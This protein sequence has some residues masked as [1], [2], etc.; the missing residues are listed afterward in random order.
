MTTVFIAI[1]FLLIASTPS[2]ANEKSNLEYLDAVGSELI[3]RSIPCYETPYKQAP[4]CNTCRW[5]K[6]I[7]KSGQIKESLTCNHSVQSMTMYGRKIPL[8][9]CY[10]TKT[11]EGHEVFATECTRQMCNANCVKV[12]RQPAK[13]RR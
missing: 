10:Y 8:D 11:P 9:T 2:E 4:R 5:L 3:S 7:F 13:Q 6:I 1:L 12:L